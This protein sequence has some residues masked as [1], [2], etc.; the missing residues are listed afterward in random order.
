MSS[1]SKQIGKIA[2]ERL[3]ALATDKDFNVSGSQLSAWKNGY[4]FGVSD[5]YTKLWVAKQRMLDAYSKALS[6]TTDEEAYHAALAVMALE[7]DMIIQE[8]KPKDE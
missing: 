3:K 8:L 7:V 5:I 2:M 1:M 4:Y 6:E